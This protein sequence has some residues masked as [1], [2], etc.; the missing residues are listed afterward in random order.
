MFDTPNI[1]AAAVVYS[2]QTPN[3]A[4]LSSFAAQMGQQGYS[5]G[6]IIQDILYDERGVKIGADAVALDNGDRFPIV[7]PS[8]EDIAAGSCGLDQSVLT[9]S[10]IILRRAIAARVDLLV[11]EKFGEREQLGEGLADD[12]MAAM[13]EG[14]PVLV[15]VPAS[16]VEKW[17]KFTGGLGDMLPSE[18]TVLQSW[19]QRRQV[20]PKQTQFGQH[21][22][23][24]IGK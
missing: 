21:E 3:K 18:I 20:S 19:W 12:I 13:S 23:I 14:I 2:A 17:K 15:A 1:H 10:S 9:E 6:G 24:G 11:V 5:V 8:K 16:A 7:R 4:A 22:V